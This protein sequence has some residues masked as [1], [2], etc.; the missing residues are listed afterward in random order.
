MTELSIV[1]LARRVVW[2]NL[3]YFTEAHAKGR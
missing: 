3:N 1:G 2:H